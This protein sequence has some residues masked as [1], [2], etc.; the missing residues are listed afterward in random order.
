MNSGTITITNV[1]KK[2][3]NVSVEKKWE[4]PSGSSTTDINVK[5]YQTTNANLDATKPEQFSGMTAIGDVW[6]NS[7]NNWKHTFSDLP[8]LSDDG[9]K[10]Y[11][12]IVEQNVPANYA[13]GYTGNG[14]NTN[15]GT[16]TV[17]NSKDK[18]VSVTAKK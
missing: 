7:G 10:Y 18:M 6:L 3:I 8:E 12:Y 17:T 1:A 11:Y 13:A 16:V 2:K 4:H 15:S 5:L 14:V 9:Q